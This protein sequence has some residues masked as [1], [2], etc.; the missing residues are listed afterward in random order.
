MDSG[1]IVRKSRPRHADRITLSHD[2][3]ARIDA[4]IDQ[5]T[6]NRK[7]VCINRGHIVN[8]LIGAQTDT[9]SHAEVSALTAI[10]FDE[11]KFLQQAMR[12]LKNAR[13]EGL[14]LSLESILTSSQ[15]RPSDKAKRRNR[16]KRCDR[17]LGVV[18]Q[19]LNTE[20]E[21]DAD[22]TVIRN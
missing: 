2:S 10:Y 19:S 7:G 14:S 9:L 13:K 1:S 18:D 5:V 16:R 21:A 12:E 8:W 15:Q 22:L 6:E 17:V 20:E 11:M 3:Q 4:W